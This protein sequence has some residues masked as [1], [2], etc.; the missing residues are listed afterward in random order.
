ML[1]ALLARFQDAPSLISAEQQNAF[2]GCLAAMV[3]HNDFARLGH[4][5]AQTDDTFWYPE[6]D[7]RSHYR[8]YIVRDGILQIP[9][10]GV[11]L[12]DFPWQFGAWGTGY[13][14]IVK[15]FERGLDDP[16]VRGIAFM[17]HSPGGEVAGCFDAC[18]RMSARRDEKPVRAFAHEYAYSAAYMCATV[19]P[20]IV[21]SRTGGVGSIGVITMHVDVSK[22]LDD[23]GYKVTFVYKGKHKKDGN[24][25]EPLSAD[26]KARIQARIDGLYDVFVASVA[27]N[28]GMDEAAVRETEALTY[29]STEA[30][31][32]G[33]ADSVGSL[34]DAV[35][36]FAA[37]LSVNEGEEQMSDKKDEAAANQTAIDTARAEGK[38]AGIA[39]GKAIGLK[40]GA[41][42]ERE[43]I[44]TIIGTENAKARPVAAMQVAMTTDMS[45]EAADAFLG[46]LPEE[47]ASVPD[48]KTPFEAAMDQERHP[49]LGTGGG[50]TAGDPG[51]TGADA[52]FASAG[53]PKRAA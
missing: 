4:E 39:E 23:A 10:R 33:L 35:A 43:R 32:V 42:G 3:R 47:A 21:M 12:H 9:V 8:P 30:I 5:K 7:W 20:H 11:L 52:I 44:K 38:T 13:A 28:R 6:D 29:S 18:D 37:D 45:A 46:G 31:S 24:P 16:G 25:Y 50:G 15:A 51:L 19:A 1:E 26:V 48:K 27:R 34:D 14:Y 17:I 22:A 2:E 40:E 49:E 36:A 41:T 53:I